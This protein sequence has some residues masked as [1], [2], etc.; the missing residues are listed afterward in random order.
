L[1]LGFPVTATGVE[2]L[3]LNEPHQKQTKK[4]AKMHG[5]KIIKWFLFDYI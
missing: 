2:S 3:F 4:Q 1:A 5:A